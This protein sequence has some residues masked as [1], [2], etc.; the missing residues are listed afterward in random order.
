MADA[1]QALEQLLGNLG[2]SSLFAISDTLT[3]VLPG[4]EVKGVGSIGFP[5][6]PAQAKQLIAKATQ[7]L[8]GRGAATIVD[9]GVRRVWQIE[10]SHPGKRGGGR[11]TTARAH[12]VTNRAPPR[13]AGWGRTDRAR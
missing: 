2:E 11:T 9:T 5:L 6:A 13:Q 4:L 8:Y 12:L 7:A 3:P 1:R 10:P